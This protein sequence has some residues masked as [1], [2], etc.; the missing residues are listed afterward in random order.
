MN[1]R[2]RLLE[3]RLRRVADH[4]PVVLVVGARQVGKTTLVQH[5]FGEVARSVVFDPVLDLFGARSDPEFFLDQHPAPLILD[6]V[7]YAPEL[8]PAL[9]R[10]VDAHPDARYILT[11]SQNLSLLKQV[12]E[13]LAGRV[14]VLELEPMT[15]AEGAGAGDQPTWLQRW[16]E[17]PASLLA[18]RD[19]LA[20][21]TLLRMLWRGGFPGLIAAP[22][23]VVGEFHASYVRTYVER[24]I[25]VMGDIRDL[26][27]FG[28]F[29]GMC[30]ALTG[31]EINHSELGRD[32]G[33]TSQTAQRWLSLLRATF[34]WSELPAFSGNAIKRVSHRPKGHFSDCGLAVHLQRLSSP[35]ALEVNPGLGHLFETFVV[36]EVRR[37]AA[38]AIPAPALYHWRTHAGAEVDLVLERDGWLW[39]IEIKCSANITRRHERGFHAFREA[40]PA[41]RIRPNL[42]VAATTEPRWLSPETLIIPWDLARGN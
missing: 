12:S 14:A 26:T 32:V 16:F 6:E 31:Q 7:Q 8:L 20:T 22:D 4:F 9:K 3:A 15:A 33:V 42:I 19:R 40:H 24:D 41:A 2:P 23:D 30:A 35:E 25:R 27:V 36:G 29:L 11:G 34:V 38:V 39:P 13:S 21:G 28:R 5:V 1:Y 37:M 18:S 17:D 10:R